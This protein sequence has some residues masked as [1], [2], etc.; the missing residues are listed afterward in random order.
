LVKPLYDHE[1][2]DYFKTPEERDKEEDDAETVIDSAKAMLTC[3]HRVFDTEDGHKVLDDLSIE[4]GEG[5]LLLYPGQPDMLNYMIGRRAAMLVIRER[6]E[7]E[8][9]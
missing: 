5:A 2:E 9:E 7:R 8:I 1:P 3:Y 6:L 4:L